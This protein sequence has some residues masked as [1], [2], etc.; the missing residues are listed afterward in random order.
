MCPTALLDVGIIAYMLNL[1]LR[2]SPTSVQLLTV[3]CVAS[4][5]HSSQES[6]THDQ[7]IR[8]VRITAM[9]VHI[10]NTLIIGGVLY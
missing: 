9:N 5:V 2:L 6:S 3:F 7:S 8:R 10:H 4:L 1:S